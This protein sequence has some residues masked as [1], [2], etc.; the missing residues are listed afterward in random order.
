MERCIE[1]STILDF[2]V[3]NVQDAVVMIYDY[4][5]PSKTLK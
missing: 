5:E 4:Y 2:K 1:I 3:A